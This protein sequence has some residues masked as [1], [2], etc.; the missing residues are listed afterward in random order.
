MKKKKKL[1]SRKAGY[2]IGIGFGIVLLTAFFTSQVVFPIMFGKPK[3]VAVPEVVG[4]KIS[5]A[6]RL[7]REIGL[8]V[9]VRDSVWSES[10]PIETVLEQFPEPGAKLKAEGTVYLVICKGSQ[11]VPVPTVIGRHFEEAFATLRN[12]G[13]R[14]LVSDSL[15]SDSYPRNMVVRSSPPGGT[16]VEKSSTVKLY[17]SRGA[18]PLPDSLR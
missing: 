14:A 18:E 10:D 3:N 17:L 9:V 13:L 7:L 4:M 11:I 15:Y 12:S 5:Q 2:I 1:N 8:H 6:K 16:R